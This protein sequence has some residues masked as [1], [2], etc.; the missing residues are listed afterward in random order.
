[1]LKIIII[2]SL[3][4]F[5][6][7]SRQATSGASLQRGDVLSRHS[8]SHYRTKPLDVSHQ[9]KKKKLNMYMSLIQDLHRLLI[10]PNTLRMYVYE[11]LYKNYN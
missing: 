9:K 1:M 10:V 11:S 2:N 8:R 5:G 4:S 7:L 6:E 3:P